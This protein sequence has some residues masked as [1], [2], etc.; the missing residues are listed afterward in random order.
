MNPRIGLALAHAEQPALH[1]V[2]Q[3]GLQVEQNAQQ[4]I[5]GRGQR[6]IR[7]GRLPAGGTRPSIAAPGGHMR[8][9]RGFKSRNQCPQL[10]DSATGHVEHLREAALEV[11]K[12][13]RP[14]G[15][16]LLAAEAHH[17]TNRD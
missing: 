9:E 15:R 11:G 4:P 14:H 8:L 17:T 13:S 16:S 6:T 5:R 12:T 10:L 7:V 3:R 2:E 1:D